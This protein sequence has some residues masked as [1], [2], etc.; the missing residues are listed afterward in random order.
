MIM[1]NDDEGE[2]KTNSKIWTKPM[3]FVFMMFAFL[4]SSTNF[5]ETLLDFI[6]HLHRYSDTHVVFL[7]FC[8][9]LSFCFCLL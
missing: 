7:C 8:I 1:T 4:R 9:T 2:K 3:C 5:K 6:H